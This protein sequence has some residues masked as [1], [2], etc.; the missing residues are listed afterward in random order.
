MTIFTNDEVYRL[1][2][3]TPAVAGRLH[4]DNCGASLMPDP[5]LA[6]LRGHLDREALVGGYV[7]HEQQFDAHAS[8][9]DRLA[10]LLG[11]TRENYA[12]TGSAVEAWNKAFYSVPFKAGDNLVTA[13]NEYCSNFVALLQQGK[14]L[15]VDV[16][17][18]KAGSEGQLDLDH[19]ESLIDKRTKLIAV[20]MVP[21]SSGQVN[22]VAEIG[23]I[24]R[25]HDILYLLDACQAIG[26]LPVNVAA[27]GC[28]M[29]TG[30][31]RKFLRGPR[32][33]GFLYVG[34]RALGALEPAM[35]SNQAASWTGD[36]QYELRRDAGVFEDWERSVGGE[37]GFGAALGYLLELGPERAFATTQA[38]ASELRSRLAQVPG[39]V[40]TCPPGANSA[41]ITFNK[42]GLLAADVKKRLEAQGIA[43][44]VA[45]AMHTRL[46]LAAR[47][48]DT[49]VRV[50]PHYF[51]ITSEFDRFLAAV[52]AL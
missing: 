35:L 43:V 51:N 7:A 47:G 14:K 42:K 3:Q 15:G 19:L 49:T 21:S 2:Q 16:R 26:Q 31:S 10:A 8:I 48:I 38:R 52:D 36:D 24:A 5:V 40:P 1:R 45:S 13:Y 4:L 18:A 46:D 28:D 44:Q 17:V 32:G 39:V 12:L 34:D 27:I 50:S 25:D 22:P 20:A 11:G 9:Y 30:T 41:I 33:I 37:L 29:L 6:T 23:K